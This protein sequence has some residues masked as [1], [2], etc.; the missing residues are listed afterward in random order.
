MNG[1]SVHNTFVTDKGFEAGERF[2]FRSDDYFYGDVVSIKRMRDSK[3]RDCIEF[4]IYEVYKHIK[5]RLVPDDKNMHKFLKD[6][7][8]E[9]LKIVMPIS[10]VSTVINN[11]GG[12]MGADS[13]E[14]ST[15]YNLAMLV[16]LTGSNLKDGA[17]IP[18]ANAIVNVKIEQETLGLKD[19]V[20]P[21]EVKKEKMLAVRFYRFTLSNGA[22][23]VENLASP[24]GTPFK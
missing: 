19:V 16:F 5:L 6:N 1:K 18:S 22:T 20:L 8:F 14:S 3:Y 23:K 15:I 4:T 24:H 17:V 9:A 21:A 13:Y 12:F 11:I 2:S 7:T 10:V